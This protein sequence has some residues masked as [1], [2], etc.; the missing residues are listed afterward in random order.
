MVHL[1][2]IICIFIAINIFLLLLVHH[3]FVVLQNSKKTPQHQTPSINLTYPVHGH[4]AEY[5]V[6][7]ER[8]VLPS[9]T[10]YD[11]HNYAF[12]IINKNKC[13]VSTN[14]SL[15]VNDTLPISVICL[16]KSA[17]SNFENRKNIRNTW[18]GEKQIGGLQIRTVFL[19]G[20]PVKDSPVQR[21]VEEESITFQDIVQG[22][23]MDKYFNN[24]MKLLMA[25]QW[26]TKFC[27]NSKFYFFVDDDYFVSMESLVVFLLNPSMYPVYYNDKNI[28]SLLN[29]NNTLSQTNFNLSETGTCEISVVLT[30]NLFHKY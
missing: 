26:G 13:E 1:R 24:T 9:V 10:P 15:A 27:A 14:I 5:A 7:L 28:D 29:R 6:E 25:L 12:K 18:G 8:G 21:R 2:R 23:F 22:D 4:V 20:S 3:F 11:Q 30:V 19:L 16:V 17:V